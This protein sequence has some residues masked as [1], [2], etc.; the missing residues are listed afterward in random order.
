LAAGLG[1]DFT[2]RPRKRTIVACL[3]FPAG[4]RFFVDIATPTPRLGACDVV[5]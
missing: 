1:P 4:L 5:R 2:G 3:G